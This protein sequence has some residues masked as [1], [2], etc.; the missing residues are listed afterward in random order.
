MIHFLRHAIRVTG[1][2]LLM[3]F[4]AI[5]YLSIRYIGDPVQKDVAGGKTVEWNYHGVVHYISIEQ[6]RMFNAL[7]YL[8]VT[9][10]FVMVLAIALQ[11]RLGCR[12]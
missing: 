1:T 4:A 5:I 3:V 10:F 2:L 6:S 11:M 7:F 8:A 12:D 9:L